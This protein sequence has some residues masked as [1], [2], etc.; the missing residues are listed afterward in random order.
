M[1]EKVMRMTVGSFDFHPS[2]ELRHAWMVVAVI[3]DRPCFDFFK[4]QLDHI[5]FFKLSEQEACVAICQAA[6]ECVA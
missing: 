5:D 4:K 2:T 6:L 1:A 3:R